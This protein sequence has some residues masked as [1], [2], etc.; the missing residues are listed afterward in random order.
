MNEPLLTGGDD[1][2]ELRELLAQYD[3]PAYVRR[4]R[5]VEGALEQLAERCRRQREEWLGLTRTRLGQVAALAGGWDAL[6]PLLA[7]DAQ[8][9]LL[10]SLHQELRPKLR[11]AIK[12]TSS[13]RELRRALAGLRNSIER[14]NARRQAYVDALDPSPVNALREAYNRHYVLEKECALRSARLAR[15]GFRRLPPL[16]ADD[17]AALM[18]PLPVPR[19]AGDGP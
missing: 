6:R 15:E 1:S 18:P 19:L 8:L 17:L 4:A 2:R 3:A 9:D 11:V 14:F 7:D 13:A 10:R 5:Q 16:T 12:P